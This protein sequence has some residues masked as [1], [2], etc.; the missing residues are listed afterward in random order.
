MPLITI[1]DKRIEAKPNQTIIQAAYDNGIEIPHFCWH[2]EL[3][4]S[5]NC[6]MCLVEVGLPKRNRDGSIETNPDGSAVVNFMPKLQI[7][8]ATKIAD[9]MVVKTNTEKV[10][11]ARE[12]IMEFIL[13]NH[14]LDCPICDEAGDC[15]LQEY[16]YRFS[17]GYSRF[18][19]EKNK[20]DKRVVWG[21]H[22][23]YDA[24]RCI[25]CSRCIR[26]AKEI[27]K[28]DILSFV[29]R[30]DRT[31]VAIEPGKEF[32]N[33]YSLN[34]V[35]L[36]PVGALTSRDFRFEARVWDMSFAPSICPGCARGCSIELGVKNNKILRIDSRANPKVNKY[37]LCDYGRL[38]QFDWVNENR[39]SEPLIKK[40]G[41]QEIVD[42]DEAIRETL[43]TLSSYKP[44]EIAIIGSAKSSTEDLYLAQ[45]FAKTALKTL[46]ID[47]F[48][49]LDETF[50]D[51]FLKRSD[52]TPNMK[53]ALAIGFAPTKN[54]VAKEELTEHIKSG[55]IKLCLVLNDSLDDY[56]D[57]LNA[58]EFLDKLV[59]LA[60][61]NS[62]LTEMADIVL[63]IASYAESDGT[64]VNFEGVV[65]R[66]KAAIATKG[67]QRYKGF[68]N[69]RLDKFGSFRDRWAAAELRNCLPAWKIFQRLANSMGANWNYKSASEIFD[70]IA[71]TIDAFKFMS[72]E[73][74]DEFSGMTLNKADKE[75]KPAIYKP[76]ILRPQET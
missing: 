8:C 6:R 61:N 33:D 3:S 57:I 35:E 10:V 34:A 72:Y 49:H 12:A 1:D 36:C 44:S 54:S 31:Y 24:E 64:F 73:K 53:G 37:W 68:N 41:K 16:A 55:K 28:Q 13:V 30:G 39:I 69:S 43:Q 29:N 50:G 40:S 38:T 17:R 63:P 19:E 23:I 21:P 27:A 65:Q 7:A 45:K 74:L 14:P 70:E 5:G 48:E 76:H 4:V 9:G 62:R 60:I 51:D 15:K 71:K 26:F 42:W 18:V 32:D 58:F 56:P 20:K 67:N 47:V 25:T 75:E 59:V 11:K 66:F 2:P 22:I 52:K 46:N